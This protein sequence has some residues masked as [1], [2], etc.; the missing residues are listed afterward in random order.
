MGWPT[1]IEYT[2]PMKILL[3]RH[4]PALARETPGVLDDERPLTPAGRAKFSL[5]ARGLARLVGR[6]DVLLT[7]P[8]TRARE[9]AAIAAGAFK[10][11][12]PVIEPAL[13]GDR[14][15]AILAALA[16]RPPEAT[17]ALVGHEPMLATLLA[18]M[19][20]A[21]D[22]ERFAFKKG[23]TALVDLPDGP[24]G[25]G[26]LVWFLPPRIL[27]ALAGA[28]ETLPAEPIDNGQAAGTKRNL[29]I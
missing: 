19:V 20:G 25:A 16:S 8:L 18:H 5:A 2:Q 29:P 4:A 24:A 23:G 6:V 15:D 12:E 3:V 27:R 17:V 9:T 21:P 11:I 1:S 14:V 10:P 7:S 22:A 26:R 13:A 28:G